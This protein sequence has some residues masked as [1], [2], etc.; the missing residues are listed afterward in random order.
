MS[1]LNNIV[2]MPSVRTSTYNL[3]ALKE[4]SLDVRSQ[5][6]PRIIVRGDNCTDLD[7]FLNDWGEM[8]LFLEVSQ[9]LLDIDCDLNIS[10]NDN[11]N[12]YLN[13]FNFFK[14]KYEISNK[15]IPVINEISPD[16]LR[17]IVQLGIKISNH[18]DLVGIILD[19][20]TNFDK[21]F[22]ILNSLLAAFSDEA[23]ANTILIIDAGKID[24][25]N[26]IN[27]DNLKAAFKIVENYNFYSII[28]SSTSYPITRPSAGETATHTCIDPVW[29]NRFNN[30]LNKIGK[31]LIYGDY[32][33]TD[34]SGEAIE[35]DFAVHPI[36]YA[37]YLLNDS[38]EWFTLREGKGGEYEK[39]RIIAQK[40]RN[41]SGYHGDNFC[42]ATNQIKSIAEH[43]RKKA[44]NQAY[45]NKLK[46]NQHISAIIKSNIDGYLGAI[47]LTH[48]EEDSDDD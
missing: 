32:A 18:F 3:G 42:Y 47:G 26:Q 30:Q 14:E 25:L 21:S 35:F 4:L 15:L 20:S 23:I 13:K 28:T 40:I 29:Q 1:I 48:N 38:F 24:S 33:A 9:Y 34:P 36:P 27:I 31:N 5:I 16:K 10:L 46:I 43:T 41:Q 44:G 19:I 7:S 8:P 17:D 2:Y 45:W 39:F 37:T 6:I 22:S 11:N 12:H